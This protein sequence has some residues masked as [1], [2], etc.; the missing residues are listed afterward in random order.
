MNVIYHN[1]TV[2]R[3]CAQEFANAVAKIAEH[4]IPNTEDTPPE[5]Q[6]Q[7]LFGEKVCLPEAENPLSAGSPCQKQTHFLQ[8]VCQGDPGAL[9]Q[10]PLMEI[11]NVDERTLTYINVRYITLIYVNLTN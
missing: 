5:P 9:S 6:Q 3:T 2:Y 8:R 11:I 4:R 1:F 7:R 10:A